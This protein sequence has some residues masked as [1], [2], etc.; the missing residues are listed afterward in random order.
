MATTKATNP[1]GFR[2]YTINGKKYVSATTVCKM[3]PKPFLLPWYAKME[4]QAVAK[5]MATI[6]SSKKL[7]SALQDLVEGRPAAIDYIEKTAKF[8]NKIHAAI[9]SRFSKAKAPKLKKKHRKCMKEFDRWWKGSGLVAVPKKAE[10]VVHSKKL[11]VA[12][13]L[14]LLAKLKDTKILMVL[15]WKT[16]S[17]VYPE[18]FYQVVIYIL[19]LQEMGFAVKSGLIVHVSRDG[20]SVKLHQVIPGKGRAPSFE[21]VKQLISFWKMLNARA[22]KAGGG[23]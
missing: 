11:G 9:E 20:S 3:M 19:C 14:D 6:T 8:G 1:D 16:G 12:G 15:D 18:A 7:R 4:K 2:F 17:G 10:F 22:K 13:T 5:L 21:K 23:A